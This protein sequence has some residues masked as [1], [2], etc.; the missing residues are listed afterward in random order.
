MD[1]MTAISRSLGLRLA[2]ALFVAGAGMTLES[3]ERYVSPN[4]NGDG[5][6]AKPWALQSA[7]NSAKPGD[8]VWI[9]GGTY[10]GDFTCKE[11]A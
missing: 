5:S 6:S 4:G 9:R 3:A 7:L 11:S 1:Y 10:S 8:T 2:A